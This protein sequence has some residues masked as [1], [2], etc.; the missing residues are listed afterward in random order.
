MVWV[1]SSWQSNEQINNFR[2]IQALMAWSTSLH[3]YES[4]QLLSSLWPEKA[5][6]LK[7]AGYSGPIDQS[8]SSDM[9][10]PIR[11]T[12][13]L[14]QGTRGILRLN[15]FVLGLQLKPWQCHSVRRYSAIGKFKH[16]L[17]LMFRFLV[18]STFIG[19]QEGLLQTLSIVGGCI[20]DLWL[21]FHAFKCQ[22]YTKFIPCLV[23]M[24]NTSLAKRC[25]SLI[26]PSVNW[27]ST[28]PQCW[29]STLK[30][31]DSLA[32]CAWNRLDLPSFPSK[33]ACLWERPKDCSLERHNTINLNSFPQEC[34][35]LHNVANDQHSI[36]QI[37]QQ[38]GPK[39]CT[40]DNVSS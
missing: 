23:G 2:L 36:P 35:N 40:K 17:H 12:Q 5:D 38:F 10:V 34:F 6:W 11:H 29:Y 8:C 21:N 30:D 27:S 4:W 20:H 15:S 13:N 37:L 24:T 3:P 25:K 32:G 39:T 16:L 9:F 14:Q 1:K 31:N 7:A 18:V 26:L 22:M 28:M 19:P 33:W